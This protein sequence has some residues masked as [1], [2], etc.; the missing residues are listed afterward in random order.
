MTLSHPMNKIK[1]KPVPDGSGFYLGYNFF[2]AATISSTSALP[3]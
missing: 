1:L 3:P 2:N